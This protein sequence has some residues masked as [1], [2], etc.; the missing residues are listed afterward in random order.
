MLVDADLVPFQPP[1]RPSLWA[2][3]RNLVASFPRS[4]YE[5][6]VTRI[7]SPMMADTLYVCEPEFIHDVLLRRAEAFQR[8]PVSRRVFAPVMGGTSIFLAEGAEWRWQRRAVSSPFRHDTMN[9]LV[10]IFAEMAARQVERW[11]SQPSDS[12]VD[13]DADMHR[14][15]FDIIVETML[16][17]RGNL[18]VEPCGQALTTAFEAIPWQA[19]LTLL[20]V[21]RWMPYPGRG[22]FLQ[23]SRYLYREFGRIVAE[24]RGRPTTSQDLL[25]LLL[26]AR[27][28]ETGRAM[29]DAELATNLLTFIAA[30]HETTAVALTWSLWLISRNEAVQRQLLEE[31]TACAGNQTIGP[32]HVDR[33]VFTRQVIQEAMRLYPPA[34]VI[35]RQAKTDTALGD[36]PV[37]AGTYITIPIF[38]LHRNSRLWENPATFDPERFAPDQVQTRSRYAYI[39][40]GAGPRVCIG[41]AFALT[42]SVVILA[43]FVRKF[44]FSPVPGHKPHPVMRVSLRPR[45]GLPLFVQR[46]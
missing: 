35:M 38:A 27:D 42:E 36:L 37:S 29:T 24:R 44:R 4:T 12:P 34:A 19:I 39:P 25:N 23:S 32:A 43:T 33:L 10:P 9:A 6:G 31:V 40:F 21:P 14:T 7:T 11:A 3:F 2:A 28:P 16:G 41:G 15:T 26:A 1:E 8:H 20:S 22:R 30:G 45:G 13:V 18:D 46:R 17:G 5:Q